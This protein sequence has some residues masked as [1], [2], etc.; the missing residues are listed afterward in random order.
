MFL[1][2]MIMATMHVGITHAATTKKTID[3]PA[4][5]AFSK[6]KC[7]GTRTKKYT[8]VIAQCISVYPP[9]GGKDN[10]TTIQVML[11]N[12][13]GKQIS[14]VRKLS[15]KNA[16]MVDI[17]IREGYLNTQ[18]FHRQSRYKCLTI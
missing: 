17:E 8:F 7:E 4:N 11:K 3:L 10:F 18:L 9:N 14:G 6:D 15:E 5:Y 13:S 1:T 12:E 2:I 16:G